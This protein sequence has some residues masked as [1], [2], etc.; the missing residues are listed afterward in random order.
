MIPPDLREPRGLL[1]EVEKGCPP[2]EQT[3]AGFCTNAAEEE[4]SRALA[5]GQ[6][7]K[8]CCIFARVRWQTP[9]VCTLQ[10]AA[11]PVGR[12]RGK[13]DRSWLEVK[14]L[15]MLFAGLPWGS[16]WC[17][18]LMREVQDQEHAPKAAAACAP[19]AS[20]WGWGLAGSTDGR[21]HPLSPSCQRD[22]GGCQTRSSFCPARFPALGGQ[23][24]VK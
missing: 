11:A 20:L 14:V 2:F 23:G 12:G 8:T 21:L 3:S 5:A 18:I 9:M 10:C 16:S 6:E 17:I 4:K 7:G 1:F 13:R 24:R 22:W 19:R 15:S